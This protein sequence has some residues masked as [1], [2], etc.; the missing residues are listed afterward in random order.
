MSTE[1]KRLWTTVM[2]PLATDRRPLGVGECDNNIS[3]H[4][5]NGML[6]W[7]I[8]G[9]PV[10]MSVRHVTSSKRARYAGGTTRVGS[11]PKIE[12]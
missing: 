7:M 2:L 9:M 6:R 4:V 3:A 5:S 8:R 1:L 12:V 10:V 11:D